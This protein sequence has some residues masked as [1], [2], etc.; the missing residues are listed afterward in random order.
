MGLGMRLAA[1]LAAAAALLFAAPAASAANYSLWV[2]GYSPLR[3]TNAGT[4]N[5]YAYFGPADRAA[6]VNKRAVSWDGQNSIANTNVYVRRALDCF[7]TGSNWCYLAGHSTGDLQIAYALSLYGASTRTVRVPDTASSDGTCNAA[8]NSPTQT[9]WNIKWIDISG[10]AAGGSELAPLGE[11]VD[12]NTDALV[13]LSHPVLVDLDPSRA[14]SLFDHNQTRGV[15]FYMFAGADGTLWSSELPGQDD[16]VVAYHSAGGVSGSPES[17]CNQS[18]DAFCYGGLT[19]G[20]GKASGWWFNSDRS[21]WSNHYVQFMDTYESYMHLP[22][23][24]AW[25][26]QDWGE[27]I[28]LER[29]DMITYAQ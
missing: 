15:M 5:D 4:Y 17:W 21:K 10:G 22:W 29:Q 13:N 26:G 23:S 6:G 19:L 28:S 11:W 24:T 12:K 14:R 18:G 20:T 1:K 8:A 16:Q 3:L 2:H 9:G 27:I 7:C 25:G